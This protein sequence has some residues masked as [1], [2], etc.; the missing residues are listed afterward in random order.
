MKRGGEATC[1]MTVATAIFEESDSFVVNIAP[2]EREGC[3]DSKLK[4]KDSE[5]FDI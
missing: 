1:Q 4:M 5:I 3:R 2:L